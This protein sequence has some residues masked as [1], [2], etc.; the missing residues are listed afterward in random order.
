MHDPAANTPPR[1]AGPPTPT[2]SLAMEREVF[3]PAGDRVDVSDPV[4]QLVLVPALAAILGP[5]DLA[6]ARR[7]VDLIRVLGVQ[8]HRH[9]RAP[10]LHAVID[11]PPAPA[12]V[13]A[14]VE[15]AVLAARGRAQAGVEGARVVRG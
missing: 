7:A 15:R 2:L 11:A 12:Q 8:G 1:D 10:G 9:H 5:E 4:G 14:A 6:V 3:S 13:V